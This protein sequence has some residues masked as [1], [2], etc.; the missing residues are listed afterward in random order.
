MNIKNHN[1]VTM[2]D[3]AN[4]AKV[5][6]TT[7]SRVLN[8]HSSI[9]KQTRKMV[10]RAIKQLGYKAIP[11]SNRPSAQGINASKSSFGLLLCSLD[12][13]TNPLGLSFFGDIVTGIEKVSKVNNIEMNYMTIKASSAHSDINIQQLKKLSGIIVMGNPTNEL[14]EI[15]NKND[16]KFVVLSSDR[17]DFEADMVVSDSIESGMRAAR[18]IMAQGK[19]RIG[20][21]GTEH[22]EERLD[23]FQIELSKK[24]LFI[25]DKDR[26]MVS[27]TDTCCFIECIHN[28]IVQGDLP[29]VIIVSFI[30]AA[31]AVK[32]MLELSKIKIPKDIMLFS[33]CHS[34]NKNSKI[35]CMQIFPKLM[36]EKAANRLLELFRNPKDIPHKIVIPMSLSQN[37]QP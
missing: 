11:L 19:T 26:K 5:S 7:V 24:G 10:Y 4:Y 23:G 16:I 30:D 15:L 22:D 29:E 33:Y 34:D 31:L 37:Q 13:Q 21:I 6:Q 25:A 18:Y 35:P 36:G 1:N 20:V 32:K 17:T 27:S 14:V 28:W 8:N 9:N 3:V 2:T 12:E